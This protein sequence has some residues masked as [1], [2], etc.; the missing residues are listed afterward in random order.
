MINSGDMVKSSKPAVG[1]NEWVKLMAREDIEYFS[2][3]AIEIERSFGKRIRNLSEDSKKMS[4]AEF[5]K[6]ENEYSIYYDSLQRKAYA[7]YENDRQYFDDMAKA[8]VYPGSGR[9]SELRTTIEAQAGNF[10]DERRSALLNAIK[11][12]NYSDD[13]KAEDGKVLD[14]FAN[15]VYFHLDLKGMSR[16][17]VEDY[18]F[19]RYES[20]RTMVH[21]NAIKLLNK[22]NF[23]SEKYGTKAFTMR[24]FMPSD[25]VERKMQTQSQSIIMRADRDIVE[26]YYAMA[27]PDAARKAE[28]KMNRNHSYGLY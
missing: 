16:D 17:E 26:E 10:Y 12:S 28:A 6:W 3:R 25:R 11:A 15:A 7:A 9:E 24:D 1:T 20:T 5:E 18:G 4:M 19:E 2:E 22:L 27:F 14:N 21:N 13:V 8:V 23:L